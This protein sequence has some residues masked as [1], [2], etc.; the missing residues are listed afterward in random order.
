MPDTASPDAIEREIAAERNAL[1]N[2]LEALQDSV[3]A[4]AIVDTVTSTVQRHGGDMGRA[5]TDAAKANPAAVALTGAGIAWL[6]F[7]AARKGKEARP[8]PVAYDER[9]EST[10]SGFRQ[11][12]DPLTS[13]FDRRV[14]EATTPGYPETSRT[15]WDRPAQRTA[16]RDDDTSRFELAF[17]QARDWLETNLD[18]LRDTASTV[19]LRVSAQVADL[20][21]R[22]E[23]G[24]D[25]MSAEAKTKVQKAR[26]RAIQGR[27]AMERMAAE[28]KVRGRTTFE[29]QPL[30]VGLAAAVAGAF[31]GAALPR[32]RVEDNAFGAF[33][34][35][36]FDEAERVWA[37][38][39]AALGQA[40]SVATTEA[41]AASAE[42]LRS[43]ASSLPDGKT[44]AEEASKSIRSGADRVAKASRDAHATAT[45]RNS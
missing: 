17:D 6:V 5:F 4:E 26:L 1:S 25:E 30:A 13:E 28:A 20:I 40:A 31:V 23:D 35:R 19:R 27:M 37:E 29:Q 2:T 44:A 9:A 32:T 16:P 15:R 38:Q 21:D 7:G 39:R 36:L 42:T 3:S 12:G 34:D 45:G 11:H 8:S 43:V 33:S 24:I 41:K 18:D 10:A 22:L 14:A